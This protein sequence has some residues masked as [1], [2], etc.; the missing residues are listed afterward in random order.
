M[1]ELAEA[2]HEVLVVSEEVMSRDRYQLGWNIPPLGGAKVVLGPDVNQVTRIVKESPPDTI[3]FIAGARGTLLGTQ[4]AIA[5]RAEDRRM[6]IITE[7]PDKRGVGGVLRWL[8]YWGEQLSLG[9]HYDFILAMGQQGVNW[10]K[11]CGY[12]GNR[13]FPFIYVTDRLSERSSES[14]NKVVRFIFVGRLVSLKGIDL[15]LRALDKLPG[16]E[17]IVIGD[18]PEKQRLMKMAIR[19]GISGRIDW[20]GQM[21]ASQVRVKISSADVL[22]LPSRKDGWGAVVNEALMAGTPVICSSAC[23]ASELIQHSW[24]GTV[25]KSEDINSLEKEM[26]QWC[27]R[28]PVS[29]TQRQRIKTWS[30]RIEAPVI[31]QYVSDILL[32][33]Y[34][35]GP[36]PEV[37]WRR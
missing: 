8:K 13:V 33:V 23:G 21:E 5:C 19:L 15:L 2:G 34:D 24:L 10:F 27:E 22:I 16:S 3:H 26:R 35:N 12:S 28:G 9:Q 31:A 1:R 36:R 29:V 4:V 11:E 17:L 7:S 14:A 6:G 25:F 20:L 30:K 37:P 32:H 18:G